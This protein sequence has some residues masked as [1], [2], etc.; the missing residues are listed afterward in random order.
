MNL[1]AHIPNGA[2][3]YRADLHIHSFGG[4]WDV[5]DNTATPQ[6]IV[7]QAKIDNLHIIAIADHNTITNVRAAITAGNSL[8]ILVIPA[9][10][11]STPQGH[12]LCY[13][14]TVELLEQFYH[15]L[16]IVDAGKQTSRCQEGMIQCLNE[17]N[18]LGGFGIIAHIERSGAFES[19]LNTMTPAKE[20]I[21]C[22]PSLLGIE[23]T[24]ATCEIKY[25]SDDIDPIRRATALKRIEKIGCG[26]HQIMARVLNSDSHTLAAVGRNASTNKRV[27]R[28]KMHTPTF[29]GLRI[30]L[31]EA[32][33]RVR[34]EDEIPLSIPRIE[35]VKFEGGFLDGQTIHFSSNLTCIIGGRG[36]GKSTT[37]SALRLI[38]SDSSE[39]GSVIDSDVWP[40]FLSLY[41]RDETNH[42]HILGRSKNFSIENISDPENGL[43]SFKIESYGQGET[44]DIV[45]E[46]QENPLTLMTFLD[47]LIAIEEAISEEDKTRTELNELIPEI[48]KSESNVAKIDGCQKELNLKQQQIA[49]LKSERGEEVIVLQQK[50]ESD[51][52]IRSQVTQQLNAIKSQAT[53]QNITSL[54]Q[55]IKTAVTVPVGITAEPEMITIQANTEAF[56]RSVGTFTGT[57]LQSA[58]QYTSQVQVLLNSWQQRD[59]TT[60]AAIEVKKAELLAAGIRLDMPFIQKLIAEE[61]RL[62]ESLAN[63][64]TWVPHLAQQRARYNEL[65]TKRWSDRGGVAKIRDEFGK[66]VSSLLKLG[67]DG[68]F[69]SLKYD[70]NNSSP[71]AF[72]LLV[73]VMGWRTTAQSKA[74]ALIEQLTVPALLTYISSNNITPILGL[75]SDAGQSI[76]TENEARTLL[77]RLSAPEQRAVLE[78]AAIHDLPR[79]TVTKKI[80]NGRSGAQ[81]TSRDFS[82]LSLGQQQS[83]LLAIMLV[84]EST[85]PLIIDQPEDNLDGEFIYKTLVPAIRRAKERR[86]VI[87]VTHNPNIAVLTDAEQI[88]AL[89]AS[90]DKAFIMCR[91]SVDDIETRNMTCAILEGAQEAFDRRSKIYKGGA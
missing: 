44:H 36:S 1:L 86:Q 46:A 7:T 28:Y 84:S 4:S 38:R 71:E 75:K 83:V 30:A 40:E 27:T 88:I 81:Y 76:F 33:T 57:L 65:M 37:F 74:T 63:L 50:L 22:H 17:L 8:G 85:A 49:R 90:N 26:I 18:K 77:D 69:I 20:D 64:N 82:R 89:K 55:T 51:R 3:F 11:L 24:V 16:N 56:E 59:A 53:T 10:E 21:I 48:R 23:I 68:L 6:N 5:T 39:E 2:Q 66:R 58:N 72:Q 62:A 70:K 29:D 79:L 78:T 42:Q 54:T 91:G 47:N 25:N 19:I 9:V 12:L 60:T 13:T 87:I 80:D 34:I 35:G 61:A 45:K 67:D 73:D 15:K 41:Y 31:Q 43:T 52:R 32:D 14:P